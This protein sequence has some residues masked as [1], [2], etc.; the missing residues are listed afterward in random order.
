MG[1]GKCECNNCELKFV[2]KG[3]DQEDTE[4]GKRQDNSQSCTGQHC[5]TIVVVVCDKHGNCYIIVIHRHIY[6]HEGKN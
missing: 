6:I 5:E 4:R 1:E 2:K 3:I